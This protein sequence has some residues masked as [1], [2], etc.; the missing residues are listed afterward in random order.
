MTH[1]LASRAA[2]QRLGGCVLHHQLDQPDRAARVVVDVQVLDVD[3]D[4]AD[5]GEQPGQLA[6]VVGH[7]DEHR[8]RRQRRSAVLARDGLGAGDAAGQD[9]RRACSA[10]SLVEHLD[11][12]RRGRPA[13]RAGSRSRPRWLARMIW[14]HMSG[15]PAAIRVTSRTPWPDSDEVLGLGLGELAGGEHGEQV[16]QVRGA[17]HRPVV[18]DRREPHRLGTAQPGQRLDQGDGLGRGVH[19]RR[20]RPRAAVEQR[21]GGGQRARPLAAGHRVAAD[22]AGEQVLVDVVGD[23]RPAAGSSRCR[24]R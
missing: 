7:R 12:P 2:A 21:G 19:V 22:V 14:L 11:E 16:R 15:S 13:R 18:L 23:L 8:R 1:S 5:V 20:D 3:P 6:G 17:G 10:S 9:L 4:L 24:R